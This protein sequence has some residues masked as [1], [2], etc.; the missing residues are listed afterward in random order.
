MTPT[1]I[2]A[3][4]LA[5]RKRYTRQPSALPPGVTVGPGV[6]HGTVLTVKVDYGMGCGGGTSAGASRALCGRKNDSG[7]VR[8]CMH[9]TY[10]ATPIPDGQ[11][12]AGN[13]HDTAI[14]AAHTAD[15]LV[16]FNAWMR[17]QTVCLD[18]AGQTVVFAR[19]YERW[20]DR[21]QRRRRS[22]RSDLRTEQ[23]A[24]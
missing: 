10:P 2:V 18:A 16:D 22:S 19:D 21:P 9:R 13:Y 11:D 7:Y 1:G 8:Q 6:P 17:G 14:E 4:V 12:M 23:G 20:V 5:A 3:R 24:Q 15:A